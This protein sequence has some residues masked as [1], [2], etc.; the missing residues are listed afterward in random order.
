MKTTT[1]WVIRLALTVQF[2]GVLA[3]PSLV[4][5]SESPRGMWMA[6]WLNPTQWPALSQSNGLPSIARSAT[7]GRTIGVLKI[8]DGKLSFVEQIGQIDWELDLAGL[9]K[10]TPANG[11]RA[12]SIVSVSGDEF[13]LTIMDPNMSQSSPKRAIAIIE[14][15][16][17]SLSANNR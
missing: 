6:E 5:A 3:V 10:V 14:R 15:A 7:E 9:K 2:L 4:A 8:R 16:V 12:I 1:L 13:V 17:Q 11:G